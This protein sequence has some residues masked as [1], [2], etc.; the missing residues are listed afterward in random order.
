MSQG[1]LLQELRLSETE[2]CSSFSEEI[3]SSP[4]EQQNQKD[5]PM[6][7]KDTV[8]KFL[9]N[10]PQFATQYFEK[11]IKADVITS[12]FNNTVQVKEPSSYKDVTAIQ[13]RSSFL[14]W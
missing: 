14:S 11:K 10:N 5:A 6:G 4:S 9:D 8:E 7:D 3:A 1:K 2:T 13:S 12:A